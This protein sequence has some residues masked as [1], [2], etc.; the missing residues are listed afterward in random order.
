MVVVLTAALGLLLGFAP[1]FVYCFGVFIKPFTSEFHAS[2]TSISFAFSLTNVMLALSSPFVGRLV[3]RF[4]PRKI[5]IPAGIIGSAAA[6]V[7]TT[8]L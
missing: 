1:I 5:I 2:R 6:P 7:P 3:D 8:R 4:G